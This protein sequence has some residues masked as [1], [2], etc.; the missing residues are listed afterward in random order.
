MLY[1]SL[2]GGP[3]FIGANCAQHERRHYRHRDI[4]T[5][6]LPAFLS[7]ASA[8]KGFVAAPSFTYRRSN[9]LH[10][11]CRCFPRDDFGGLFWRFYMSSVRNL[12]T[13]KPIGFQECTVRF[14]F[15]SVPEYSRYS[16]NY[17]PTVVKLTPPLTPVV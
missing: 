3:I 8:I 15:N 11:A 14:F 17:H 2:F 16:L 5:R 10:R 6:R 1:N 7:S 12:V 4:R 13:S 9:W